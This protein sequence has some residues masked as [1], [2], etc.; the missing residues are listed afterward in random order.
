MKTILAIN[1]SA[2]RATSVTRFLVQKTI[3][4]LL[5]AEPDS[6]IMFRELDESPIPHLSGAAVGGIRNAT[7]TNQQEADAQALSDAL[8]GELQSADTVVIGAPMYNFGISST[9]KAWFDYVLRAGAT[10]RY[11]VAGPEGLL[12]GKRAIVIQARGG[13]YTDGPMKAMD[14]Q[15]PHLRTLLGFMGIMDVSYIH[16][17]KLAFGPEAREAAIQLAQAEI[18][19]ILKA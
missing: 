16:A 1:S 7:P 18:E 13:L 8:I 3:D 11:T 14:S 17:E 12:R 10:F 2:L 6:S 19:R 15:E 4:Q 5:I 9:L